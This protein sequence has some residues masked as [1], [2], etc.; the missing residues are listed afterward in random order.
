[1]AANDRSRW[2]GRERGIV[3]DDAPHFYGGDDLDALQHCRDQRGRD[4][5][6]AEAALANK[7]RAATSW[8]RWPL[9]VERE[10]L[11]Q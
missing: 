5:I 11:A 6:I 1:M 2:A 10:T 4:P 7:S 3:G 9:A 8:L